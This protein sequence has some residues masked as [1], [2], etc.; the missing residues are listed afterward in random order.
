MASTGSTSLTFDF[1]NS[2]ASSNQVINFSEGVVK[3]FTGLTEFGGNSTAAAINQDGFASGTLNTVSIGVDGTIDGVFTNGKTTP[4]AQL[5]V[6]QFANAAGL[7]R[8]GNNLFSATTQSGQPLVGAGQSA[9]AAAS[10]RE[11]WNSRT[12]MWPRR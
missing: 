10:N 3:G 1:S 6:A 7:S 11:S 2:G 9:G 12:W 4:L 8:Q 5:A